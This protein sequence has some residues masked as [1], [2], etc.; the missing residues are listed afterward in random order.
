MS[1]NNAALRLGWAI[2]LLINCLMALAQPAVEMADNLRASGKIYVVVVV[3]LLI[4]AGLIA[5]LV[6]VERKI[7]RL[8]KNKDNPS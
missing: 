2:A 4:F 3:I 6:S 5:F 7:K 8:E 1:Y